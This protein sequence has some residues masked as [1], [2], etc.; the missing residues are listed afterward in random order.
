MIIGRFNL[1]MIPLL[2]LNAIQQCVRK[3]SFADFTLFRV[4]LHCRHDAVDHLNQV[5]QHKIVGPQVRVSA[6]AA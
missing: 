6:T 1:T 2:V 3:R 5:D 4:V